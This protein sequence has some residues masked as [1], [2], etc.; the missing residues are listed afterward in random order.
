MKTGTLT[1]ARLGSRAGCETPAASGL[2]TTTQNSK[3]APEHHQKTTRRHTVRDKKS[4][5]GGGRRKKTRNFGPPTLWPHPIRHTPD[6]E[7]DWPKLDWPKLV[8]S[9]WPKRDWPK[10]V[11]SVGVIRVPV[12]ARGLLGVFDASLRDVVLLGFIICEGVVFVR[13]TQLLN[14]S[15]RIINPRH[16]GSGRCKAA[17]RAG[18]WEK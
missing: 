11:F 6:L 15:A 8:K 12:V 16:Q 9:G 5:I 2:H 7:M 3:R 1:C 13:G 14:G 17:R 4:E 10:S 18:R